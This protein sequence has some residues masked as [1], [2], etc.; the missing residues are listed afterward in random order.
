MNG[1]TFVRIF[2]V[3]QVVVACSN[4]LHILKLNV[5]L[6]ND[7]CDPQPALLQMALSN[8]YMIIDQMAEDL[9]NIIKLGSISI[10]QTCFGV[11]FSL[12]SFGVRFLEL[13]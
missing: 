13:G 3:S 4:Y 5:Q 6:I 12:V 2:D 9:N 1:F 7:W 10:I 11:D 8:E